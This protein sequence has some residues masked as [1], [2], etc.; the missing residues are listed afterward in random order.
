MLSEWCGAGI[1]GS[2]KHT[3]AGWLPADMTISA[4]TANGRTVKPMEAEKD[5]SAKRYLQQIRRLDTKINRDIE[6]LHRLK[7]MV[8]KITPTL[9]PDVVSCGGGTQDKLAEA[10]A[11]IIDLEAEF[12]REIDRLVDART[13]V[14]ATIDKVEDARLHTVLNMRYVQFKTWEQI[15]CYMGRSYQ[16][17]CKLHG[18]A[19]KVIEKIIK[20]SEEND[21]S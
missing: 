14:T 12:N 1:A 6:E 4:P 16:W 9:K 21:I 8:T 7:A 5:N 13:A 11:K 20:I 10:M 17:V 18:T 15:A 19:L 3:V 2:S